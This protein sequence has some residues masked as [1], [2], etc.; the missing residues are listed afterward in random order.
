M[1]SRYQNKNNSPNYNQNYNPNYNPNN[2][3]GKKKRK[4]KRKKTAGD[5]I[6]LILM[7][8]ALGVFLFSA[9]TLYGFYKEYKKSADEYD[10]LESSYTIEIDDSE[11]DPVT[12]KKI[13][14]DIDALE[15]D[16]AMEE[17]AQQIA[18]DEIETEAAIENGQEVSLPLMRNPIDFESL[19]AVNEDIVGWL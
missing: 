13:L 16:K 6:S 7:I 18:N 3:G 11:T 12:E 1:G 15:D 10:N 17:L 5:V 14:K 2:Q 9:Y 4:K 8:V 19:L